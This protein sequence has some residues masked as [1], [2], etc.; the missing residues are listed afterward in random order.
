MKLFLVEE[1]F[2]DAGRSGL[3]AVLVQDLEPEE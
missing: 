1:T 3:S 2:K